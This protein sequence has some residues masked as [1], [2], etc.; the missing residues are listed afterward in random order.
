MM[1][2]IR[3]RPAGLLIKLGE[4]KSA[5]DKCYGARVPGGNAAPRIGPRRASGA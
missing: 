3:V 2:C 5:W 1:R 4:L